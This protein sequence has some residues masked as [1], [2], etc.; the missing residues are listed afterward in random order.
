MVKREFEEPAAEEQPDK[1][2]AVDTLQTEKIEE[3]AAEEP[4]AKARRIATSGEDKTQIHWV[5]ASAIHS[6]SVD[7]A[8]PATQNAMQTATP[9]AMQ[10]A[11]P[12]AAE[13]PVEPIATAVARANQSARE[14][15]E[16]LHTK[17]LL[18]AEQ[19]MK[20]WFSM[21]ERSSMQLAAARDG[22]RRE[23]ELQLEPVRNRNGEIVGYYDPDPDIDRLFV[24][25]W[26]PENMIMG[27]ATYVCFLDCTFD[28]TVSTLKTK[29]QQ[30]PNLAH[31]GLLNVMLLY[32][33]NLLGDA[34]TL[35]Q[36]GID[37]DCILHAVNGNDAFFNVCLPIGQV[38]NF[39]HQWRLIL[40][41]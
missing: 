31:M 18:R 13:V 20:Y 33:G 9:M 8:P 25:I 11:T 12:M 39:L 40:R 19:K 15:F 30:H 35:L 28:D 4:A 32:K 23:L 34:E 14:S 17:A 3:Q 21:I 41:Q 22:N 6:F 37:D 29:I 27:K 1:A 5:Q 24:R 16:E 7:S 2:Q 10:T 26:T 36:C 38:S